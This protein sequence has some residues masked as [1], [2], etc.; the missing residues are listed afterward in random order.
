MKL[1]TIKNITIT[2]TVLVAGLGLSSLSIADEKE[3]NPAI[4]SM[5]TI[6]IDKSVVAGSIAKDEN[7]NMAF[8]PTGK[9]MFNYT[10]KVYSVKTDGKTA[11]LKSLNKEVGTI[12]GQAAFPMDFGMLAIGVKAFMYGAGPMPAIPPVIEWTC[13]TCRMVVGKSVYQSIVDVSD[14]FDSAA[15]EAMK[16]KGRAFTGL[17]PVEL[18]QL[19]AESMTVRMAGCSAVVG[20]EG[21]NAGKVGTL[22]LNGSFTFDLAGINLSNPM[23]STI[24]GTGTSNCI[25]VLHTP[26]AM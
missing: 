26:M 15:V 16:M 10:G 6:I 4:D 2:A 18:G 12:E 22:C 25:T 8:D 14:N 17:G 23:Q 21:P 20:V 3:N 1:E 24:T 19:S 7:G 11:E 9:L 13:N 5:H